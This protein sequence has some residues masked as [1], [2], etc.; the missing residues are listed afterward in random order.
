MRLASAL[1]FA[2]DLE[3]GLTAGWSLRVP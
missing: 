3:R 2:D 1:I